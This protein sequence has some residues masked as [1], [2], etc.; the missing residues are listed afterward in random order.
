[1]EK[2]GSRRFHTV[3]GFRNIYVAGENF[4]ALKLNLPYV[5][6]NPFTLREQFTPLNLTTNLPLP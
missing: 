5:T 4:A 1:M 3:A 2:L 6:M